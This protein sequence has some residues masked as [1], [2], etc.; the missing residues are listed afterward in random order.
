MLKYFQLLY[1]CE[2]LKLWNSSFAWCFCQIV[3]QI[4]KTSST[5]TG[6]VSTP[7]SKQRLARWQTQPWL[8]TF[9]CFAFTRE[10]TE[11]CL[12]TFTLV[13]SD[14][15]PTTFDHGIFLSSRHV[16]LWLKRSSAVPMLRMGMSRNCV[17]GVPN[18]SS[19]SW[20]LEVAKCFLT[21][22]TPPCEQH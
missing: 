5:S 13:V 19:H 2:H 20:C 6:R 15:N 7:A 12:P 18:S 17:I 4:H 1:I 3:E 22:F 9:G 10:R 21:S 16:S 11:L 14:S 8:K